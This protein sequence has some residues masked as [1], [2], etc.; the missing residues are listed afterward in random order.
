[1]EC[2]VGNGGQNGEDNPMTS[3]TPC[4][5]FDDRIEDAID[6]YTSVFK[7]GKVTNI[8]RNQAGGPGPEGTIL[9]A[10][11]ELEGQKFIALNGGPQFKFTEAVSFFVTCADQQEVDYYWSKLT[12]D[13]G[14]ESQ[15]GWLRD[16]YGLSWQII[17]KQLMQMIGSQDKAAAQRAMQAMLKMGKIIV[18]DLEKAYAA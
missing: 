4:L 3:I 6:F 12:A 2:R 16:K 8:L 1:M 14:A 17:P 11:F 9:T 5:W 15:C 7:N 13:G 18:A 10:D